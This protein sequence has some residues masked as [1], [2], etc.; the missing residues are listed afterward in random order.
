MKTDRM[1]FA[2]RADAGRRLA[3]AVAAALG[4]RPDDRERPLVLAIPRG[5]V[6]IGCA[7][8]KKIQA[9]L[10]IVVC[11]K[12]PF[13]DNPESGFGA[14]AED[15]SVFLHPDAARWVPA[16]LIE[17]IMAEQRAEIMRRIGIL[18]RGKSLPPIAGRTVILVDD[19]LAMGST[20]RAAI[21]LCRKAGAGR[22]AVAV[23][24]AAPDVA[25]AI[26]KLAD[27]VVILDTPP[28]FRAVA[29][30]YANWYDVADDEVLQFLG[31]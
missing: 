13:P 29:D 23:P 31:R 5:G 16:P 9:D 1:V 30:S 22:I 18:R 11:R 20:M 4:E 17:S 24:V 28:R 25:A 2:D 15:G 7:V 26:K 10:A 8:A 6:E 19:G 27:E 12:L 3:E 14:I 21:A